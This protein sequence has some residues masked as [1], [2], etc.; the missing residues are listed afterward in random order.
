MDH[1]VSRV[2][3]SQEIVESK[4]VNNL[5]KCST[6]Y[7]H[8]DQ[9]GSFW[10]SRR[11]GVDYERRDPEYYEISED[12]YLSVEAPTRQLNYFE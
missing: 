1:I 10:Y 2:K 6:Y 12:E 4:R 11:D 3:R 9:D 8:I 5:S 7:K